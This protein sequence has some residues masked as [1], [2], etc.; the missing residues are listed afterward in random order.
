MKR[1]L[2]M[3]ASMP[4]D[5]AL[6]AL[7]DRIDEK[8]VTPVVL[9]ALGRFPVRSV[10]L[11]ASRSGGSTAAARTC[12]ELL[13]GHLISNPGLADRLDDEIDPDGLRVLQAIAESNAAVPVAEESR[14]PPLLVSPPWLSRAKRS[15]PPV[16][17]GLESRAGLA[18]RW[19]RDW[20]R[21]SKQCRCGG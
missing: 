20:P 7:L 2:G 21:G 11:L 17:A 13:R 14:L 10:R 6:E 18:L 9:E 1:L 15:K 4:T 8:Y 19:L 3:L 16:V 5:G 12:R